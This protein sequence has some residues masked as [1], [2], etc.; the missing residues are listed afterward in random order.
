VKKGIAKSR[1]VAKGFGEE[2]PIA[3]N[4]TPEGRAQN[5]RVVFTILGGGDDV[6]TRVQGAGDDTK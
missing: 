6:K 2:K 1:L 4:H 3:D 5:R